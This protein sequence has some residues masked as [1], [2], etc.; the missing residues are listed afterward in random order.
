MKN[1]LRGHLYPRRYDG[2]RVDVG[3]MFSGVCVFV[4]LSVCLFLHTISQKKTM[5]LGSPN[6]TQTLSTTSPGNHLLW[7][8]KV[9][10]QGREAQKQCWREF[11][12]S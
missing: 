5:H 10:G 9:R 7:G 4:C 1:Q 2:T 6:V 11:L 3:R 8:Q 12:D